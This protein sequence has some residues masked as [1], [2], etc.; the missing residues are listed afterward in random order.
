MQTAFAPSR[1]V[2]RSMLRRATVSALLVAA[3]CAPAASQTP[4]Q[5]PPYARVASLSGPRFG[6]TLLSEG[7]MN[8]LASRQIEVGPHVSQFGWQ[9]EKQFYHRDGGLTMVTEWVALLGGLEQNVTLPS[10]SWLVGARTRDGAEFGIGPNI[11][12]AGTA[13]VV[14]AGVTFRTGALNIPLNVAV[15]PSKYGSR[16]TVLSGFSLRRR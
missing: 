15:V 16:V 6:F 10:L 13:I 5:L 2:A 9:F 11:T 12:P 3:T 14:A 7:V 1:S 8:E 4:S